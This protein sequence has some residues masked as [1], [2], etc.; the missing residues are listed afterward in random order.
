MACQDRA[1]HTYHLVL[2]YSGRLQSHPVTWAGTGPA[3]PTI[4]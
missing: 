2:A 3:K 1:C 4:R